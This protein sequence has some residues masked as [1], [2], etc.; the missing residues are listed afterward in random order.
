MNMTN[1]PL[2]G[3]SYFFEGLQ[4]LLKP[5]IKKFVIIPL[6]INIVLFIGLFFLAKHY[7]AELNMWLIQ[8]LPTW[9]HWLKNV[10][11]VL[12]FISFFLVMIFT[13]V[14]LANI[15]GAPFN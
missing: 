2:I 11:W 4:L 10:L 9:L 3:A 8:H 6:L 5:G 14:T 12:F 1:H 7:F 13:F 15:V